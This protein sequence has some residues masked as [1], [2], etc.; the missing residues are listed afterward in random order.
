VVRKSLGMI[1]QMI[2]LPSL[3]GEEN[4][5][6]MQ[7]IGREEIFAHIVRL[8]SAPMRASQCLLES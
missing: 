4:I 2:K 3:V 6:Q 5:G 7:E 1:A 8:S